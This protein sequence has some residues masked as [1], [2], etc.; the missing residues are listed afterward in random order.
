MSCNGYLQAFKVYTGATEGSSEGL[1]ATV[2]KP[3]TNILKKKGYHLYFND[4]F[5]SVDLAQDLLHDDLYCIAT[6]RTNRKKWPNS[7]KD[8]EAQKKALKRGDH[9]STVVD[10][11]VEC[12]V[13]KDNRCVPFI[14]TISRPG[15]HTTV[16][17]KEKDGRRQDVSCPLPVKLYN[18]H[19]GGVDLADSRRKLY[20]CRS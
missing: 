15:T 2:V 8:M 1:G 9:I 12:I 7:M 10:G 6:T 5:S 17:R 11:T 4:F 20:S 13:W 14:N 18:Q 3:L 19:M 16:P